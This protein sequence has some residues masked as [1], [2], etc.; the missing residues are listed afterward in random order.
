MSAE[1]FIEVDTGK[2][3]FRYMGEGR[4]KVLEPTHISAL[5]GWRPL[6]AVFIPADVLHVVVAELDKQRQQ[7]SA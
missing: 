7:I 4:W 3:V 2:Y 6:N 5:D 1:K